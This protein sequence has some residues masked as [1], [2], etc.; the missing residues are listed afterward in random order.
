[1]Q[2]SCLIMCIL[3]ILLNKF[4]NDITGEADKKIC[5]VGF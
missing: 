3:Y 4:A 5:N 1:M 2:D